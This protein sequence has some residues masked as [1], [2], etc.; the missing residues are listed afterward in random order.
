VT[1][2]TSSRLD[3]CWPSDPGSDPTPPV[4][5]PPRACQLRIT[6]VQMGGLTVNP[7]Q[8]RTKL[9]LATSGLLGKIRCLD[10]QVE[11]VFRARAILQALWT[12]NCSVQESTSHVVGRRVCPACG[13]L[14]ILDTSKAEALLVAVADVF[15]SCCPNHKLILCRGWGSSSFIVLVTLRTKHG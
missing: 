10:V 15:I 11:A 5:P 7:E 13:I 1:T 12:R 2:T 4:K 14:A 6:F 3:N 9:A 8:D